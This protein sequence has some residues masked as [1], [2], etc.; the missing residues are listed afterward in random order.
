MQLQSVGSELSEIL[1]LI[2]A[3]MLSVGTTEIFHNSG[4]TQ[5][6]KPLLMT[7]DI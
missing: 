5:A 6:P 7:T 2:D 3:Q 4:N 1:T